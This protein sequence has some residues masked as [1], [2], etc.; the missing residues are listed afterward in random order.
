V[1]EVASGTYG[2]QVI[3]ARQA[4]RNLTPGCVPGVPTNCIVF[5]T[6]ASGVA[7]I[8]GPLE[9]RG[10]SV[11]VK[12]TTSPRGGIPTRQ[13]QYSIKVR[14][15]VDTE[16]DSETVY[17]DHVIVEGV[18]A[19]SF[20]VFNVD[21]ATFRYLDVGPATVGARCRILEGPGFENKIGFG[22]GITVVP[23]NITL[24]NLLIHDQ[25][26]D[27]A[28]AES[29]CHFGGLFLV[30]AAGLTI[31]NSVFSRNVVYNIQVQNFDESPAPTRVTIENNWFGCPVGWL[32]ETNG[33]TQC[34]GQADIQFNAAS[35][36]SQWLIRHNSFG[37]GL[38]Q[39]VEGASYNNIRVVGNAGSQSSQCYRA[40]SFA[41]NAW[42]GPR[43][44]ATDRT[45]GA[46]PFVST[47]PGSEDFRLVPGSRA[48]S[49]VVPQAGDL[50]LG[51]D[52][53][54]QT[55][56]LRYP[57]DAGALERDTAHLALGVSIG[58]AVMGMP[59]AVLLRRYGPP[60][61]TRPTT[62]GIA[63]TRAQTDSFTV[64]GGLVSATTV[65]DR[66]VGLATRSPFY[67]NS[68]GLGPGSP[69]SDVPRAGWAVCKDTLRRRVGGA[70]VTLR[71]GKGKKPKV[72]E[73]AMLRRA[74]D[75]PCE[76]P[77]AK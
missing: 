34:N 4:T 67:T 36:F 11:W 42:E 6:A 14:G 59:R 50:A 29:D 63:K 60:R 26:R 51:S 27:A 62:I 75:T 76:K 21:T 54:G 43:C 2:P 33:T 9:I 40:W 38:G 19:T 7:T 52:M 55:R 22:S 77:P 20:G 12:G 58:S 45:L 73:V 72:V 28:G 61:R 56:P 3:Q 35:L 5:R 18:D 24:D 32:Y 23:R 13:R 30:T 16:A 65:G 17:P 66:V 25:N 69:V 53:E 74:Y 1:I 64:P 37:G 71:L 57:R 47:A 49:L 10:S 8:Q 31:R 48:R 70:I 46:S 39:Y 68:K 44:G 41:Y 15:Y